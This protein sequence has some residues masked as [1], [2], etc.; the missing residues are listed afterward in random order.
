METLAHLAF[1][2]VYAGIVVVPVLGLICFAVIRAHR[3]CKLRSW[4]RPLA[5]TIGV[6][7][8]LV[9]LVPFPFLEAWG[10][11]WFLLTL[12]FSILLEYFASLGFAFYAAVTTAVAALFWGAF[13][14]VL[15]AVILRFAG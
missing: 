7:F 8:A 10:F 3:I 1:T 4:P 9:T 14:Y 2:A 13:V 5:L 15:S 12:P 6:A 11:F